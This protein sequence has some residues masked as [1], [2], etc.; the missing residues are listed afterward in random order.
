MLSA[1]GDKY[2]VACL[3]RFAFTVMQ[4]DSA[5]SN[6]HID[7]ILCVWCLYHLRSGSGKRDVE[8]GAMQNGDSVL[9]LGAGDVSPGVGKMNHATTITHIKFLVVGV[10]LQL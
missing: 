5:A 9:A 4:C 3:A 6:Y 1:G 10:N 2:E 7:L 8:R